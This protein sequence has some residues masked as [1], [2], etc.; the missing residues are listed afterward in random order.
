[1]GGDEVEDVGVL[2]RRLRG[3]IPAL[4]SKRRMNKP[5]PY[6]KILLVS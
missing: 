6:C 4:R 5:L 2:K 3:D 1:M